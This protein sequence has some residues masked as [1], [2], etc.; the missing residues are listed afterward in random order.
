M[1]STLVAV[2]S[3]G[4]KEYRKAVKKALDDYGEVRVKFFDVC[5][6]EDLKDD[7]FDLILVNADK[8]HLKPSQDKKLSA[9]TKN[10]GD[11]RGPVVLMLTNNLSATDFLRNQV[12]RATDTIDIGGGMEVLKIALDDFMTRKP[13]RGSPGDKGANYADA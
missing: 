4:D 3:Y 9:V 8:F 1:K 12:Y 13:S 2:I 6:Q 5:S 11:D 10:A 7:R